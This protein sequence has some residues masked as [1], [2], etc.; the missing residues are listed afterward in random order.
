MNI[1]QM[2]DSIWL[3]F[4]HFHR[5]K[6]LQFLNLISGLL[7]LGVTISVG[8]SGF[9]NFLW[10]LRCWDGVVLYLLTFHI[11]FWSPPT[12]PRPLVLHHT[13]CRL[14][15]SSMD[16]NGCGWPIEW[17]AMCT[18]WGRTNRQI[19][20]LQYDKMCTDFLL[21][22]SQWNELQ[23]G[24]ILKFRPEAEYSYCGEFE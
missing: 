3:R 19:R 11:N 13:H 16:A 21:W 18:I 15:K 14:S 6:C 8:C 1:T 9:P 7:S 23:I 17:I 5:F 12:L 10:H 20:S 24:G 4:T 22:E 2:I